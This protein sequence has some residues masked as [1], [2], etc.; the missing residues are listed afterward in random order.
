MAGK[1]PAA[2]CIIEKKA[3]LTR[4]VRSFVCLG[5]FLT[6]G[7]LP[8]AT[9]PPATVLKDAVIDGEAV[10]SGEVR[11]T[12]TVTVKK[13]GTLTILPGTR[14]LF[15]RIDRDQDGIGDSE[16]YVE[17]GLR[18]IGTRENPITLSSAEARPAP[19]DWKYLY[20]DYSRQAELENVLSEYA[21]SGVQIHFCKATVRE[22]EFRHNIDGVRFSTANVTIEGNRIHNNTHGIRYEERRGSGFVTG[23]DIID[24]DIGVFVVTRGEDRT[25]FTANNIVNRKYNVKLGID[26]Y[27][28]ITLAGNWWGSSDPQVIAAGFFDRASDSGLGRVLALQPLVAPAPRP[29]QLQRSQP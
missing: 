22:S 28:D 27:R 8:A 6:G 24:N 3:R 1:I 29:V 5:F 20:L 7:C 12:G 14:I 16:I 25:L 21:Y 17:G 13:S 2:Q 10:W 9:S 26:Q 11:V 18:A 19:A 15:T 4:L 23:N